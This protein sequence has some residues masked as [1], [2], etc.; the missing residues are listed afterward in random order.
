MVFAPAAGVT[1]VSMPSVAD[2]ASVG[3]DS[4]IRHGHNVATVAKSVDRATESLDESTFLA[5]VATGLITAAPWPTL[6]VSVRMLA[7]S[8]TAI[9]HEACEGYIGSSK[10]VSF[11]YSAACRPNLSRLLL[12]A[13]RCV[14]GFRS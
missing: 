5:N 4:S 9:L 11:R 1:T 2:A 8:A 13:G 3:V 7:A 6:P 10:F 12:R 14:S